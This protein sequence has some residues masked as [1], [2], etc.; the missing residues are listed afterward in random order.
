[1]TDNK[2]SGSADLSNASSEMEEMQQTSAKREQK[3]ESVDRG[4]TDSVDYSTYKRA[5]DKEKRVKDQLRQMEE[6]LAFFEQK[7][8]EAKEKKL[9]EQQE[10]QKIAKLKDEEVKKLS[11]QIVALRSKEVNALRKD[12]LINELGGV[13]RPEYLNFAPIDMIEVVDGVPDPHSVKL[14]AE[15]FR[16]NYG[17]LLAGGS[18][19][20]K[21]PNRAASAPELDESIPDYSKDPAARDAALN[22]IFK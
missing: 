17:D 8:Q 13:R 12:A 11:D 22:S 14:V 2:Q 10:W 21:V 3:L 19:K 6:R 5:V 4:N 20:P 15:E 7:E 18:A 1:M 16:K 9:A